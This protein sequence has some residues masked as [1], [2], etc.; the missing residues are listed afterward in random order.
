MPKRR[1]L[2]GS[3]REAMGE[4]PIEPPEAPPAKRSRSAL[5]TKKEAAAPTE[6]AAEPKREHPPAGSPA[7]PYE[8]ILN[9]VNAAMRQNIE[10]G[11]RLARC[12]SPM[13]AFAAQTAHAAALAQNLFAVSIKLMQASVAPAGWTPIRRPG[14]R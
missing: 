10:T 9:F 13:E 14:A 7:T 2:V 5:K 8:A 12:K 1:S 6:A 4:S 11:A 3:A